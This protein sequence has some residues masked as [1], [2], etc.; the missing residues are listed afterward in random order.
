MATD[1]LS[2]VVWRISLP[3]I[4]AQ[5]SEAV[6]HVID[7]VFL[8]RVGVTE[9]GAL[10]LA[11]SL[12]LLF[13]VLPLALVDAIQILTARRVGQRRPGAVGATFNQGFVLILVVCGAS[14][15]A[16]KLLSPLLA[17]WF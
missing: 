11:D 1:S 17:V 4:F 16:L 12:L 9:L 6:L 15:V 13:L 14:T 3:I 2:R 8:A 7:T 10:A 5:T